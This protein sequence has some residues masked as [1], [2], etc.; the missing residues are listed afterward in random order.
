MSSLVA[1]YG[2][3][4]DSDG[5]P[6]TDSQETKVQCED[7]ASSRT[8]NYLISNDNTDSSENEEDEHA[9]SET[10]KE[11]LPNPL[12]EKLPAPDLGSDSSSVNSKLAE[13][14]G[15]VFANPFE[16]AEMAK[17]SILEKHVKMTEAQLLTGKKAKICKAFK[18]GRCRF[19]K[20]CKFSHDLD[21]NLSLRYKQDEIVQ[22]NP[23]KLPETE[24]SKIPKY[25]R[26]P[27]P[28]QQQ[29]F[30]GTV[31]TLH[32][33]P[34]HVSTHQQRVHYVQ[35]QKYMN[36]ADVEDDD[37]FN[38]GDKRKKRVGL[39]QSLVPP[40]KAMSS[41]TKQRLEERPWTLNKK[42]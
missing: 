13:G 26:L 37:K 11:K 28:P 2:T 8:Q 29:G 23:E 35:Q 5:N 41:L 40:K 19:G 20:N 32:S 9:A 6:E 42:Q 25:L 1:D 7:L 10:K 14:P 16:T 33:G 21:A 38:A 27:P 15:S 30:M 34:K 36:T 4:S 3:D 22:D 24:K 39:S 12:T 18:Q 17:Q 31:N